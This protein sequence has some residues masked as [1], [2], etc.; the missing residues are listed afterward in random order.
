VVISSQND[1]ID[2]A[3]VKQLLEQLAEETDKLGQDTESMIVKVADDVRKNP[4]GLTSNSIVQLVMQWQ[5]ESSVVNS[6]ISDIARRIS[7]GATVP[8]ILI[9]VATQLLASSSSINL[10]ANE[11]SSRT[12]TDPV[13]I[14]KAVTLGAQM[15]ELYAEG[16]AIIA[17]NKDNEHVVAFVLACSRH[18]GECGEEMQGF[19]VRVKAGIDPG[20]S[21]R[22]AREKL[23]VQAGEVSPLSRLGIYNGT[24][25]ATLS[26]LNENAP[27]N[28]WEAQPSRGSDRAGTISNVPTDVPAPEDEAVQSVPLANEK[29]D[30]IDPAQRPTKQQDLFGPN[31]AI[32]GEQV[33]DVD[34]DSNEDSESDSNEDSESDSNEDSESDS[35]EEKSEE[36]Q[37]DESEDSSD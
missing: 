28:E 4:K 31:Q 22:L 12:G 5:D 33:G 24:E 13:S 36:E 30:P 1:L 10:V 9:D 29:I 6:L 8:Q 34:S 18:L 14:R 32:G 17:E 37:E 16:S 15:E 26:P 19:I 25:A 20:E 11:I 35:N 23:A 21:A 27:L 3:S 2:L 7:Q